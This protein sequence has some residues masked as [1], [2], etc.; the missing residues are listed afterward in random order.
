MRRGISFLGLLLVSVAA[1]G[2]PGWDIEQPGQLPQPGSKS[3]AVGLGNVIYLPMIMSDW[4][5]PRVNVPHFA[6]ANIFPDRYDEMA[7]FWLG[8]VTPTENYAD[9][10][11]GY[12]DTALELRVAIIDR[13]LWFDS[14]P[15]SHDLEAWDG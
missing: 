15:A 3:I 12:S 4:S 1:V 6:V 10:R 11:I 8:R 5:V 9:V 14:S 2:L 13:L 7:V